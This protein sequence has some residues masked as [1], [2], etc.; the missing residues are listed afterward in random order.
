MVI[1]TRRP[2]CLREEKPGTYLMGSLV[3]P[4]VVLGVLEKILL[5]LS[6]FEHWTVHPVA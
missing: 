5:S 3:G 2:L 4:T 6:G 1:S